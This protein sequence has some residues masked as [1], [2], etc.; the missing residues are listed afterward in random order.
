MINLYFLLGCLH[1]RQWPVSYLNND[2]LRLD[3]E[4]SIWT[5]GWANTRDAGNHL[6]RHRAHYDVI[7]MTESIFEV[8][9]G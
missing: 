9:I 7:V 6:R 4:L 8:R 1:L 5:N 3:N 2:A